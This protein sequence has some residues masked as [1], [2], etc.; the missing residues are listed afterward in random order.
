[1]NDLERGLLRFRDSTV[2]IVTIHFL[3]SVMKVALRKTTTAES[4]V[5]GVEHF[6]L[7]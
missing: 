3:T 4:R 1:M 6:N 7:Y 5:E 2:L